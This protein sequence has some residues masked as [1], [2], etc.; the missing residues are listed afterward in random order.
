MNTRIQMRIIL[1]GSAVGIF[2]CSLVL[3]LSIHQD[4]EKNRI[5]SLENKLKVDAKALL[6][7]LYQ[8]GNSAWFK[9]TLQALVKDG[10]TCLEVMDQSRSNIWS[11]GKG[12]NKEVPVV[13]YI[14]QEILKIN[15]SLPE[16]SVLTSLTKGLHSTTALFLMLIT[17][18]GVSFY[19][20]SRIL[21]Q[22]EKMNSEAEKKDHILRLTRTLGHNLKSPLAALNSYYEMTSARLTKDEKYF[23]ISIQKNIR[24]LCERLIDQDNSSIP[25]SKVELSQLVKDAIDLKLVEIK[26]DSVNIEVNLPK[27]IHAEINENEF[28]VIISNLL[29]N[30][31]EAK[32]PGQGLTIKVELIE[33]NGNAYLSI[34][35][36]GIGVP[37][38]K[39]ANLFKYGSTTKK[40][41]KGCGLYHAKT[42]LESWAGKIEL[43]SEYLSY[44]SVRLQIPTLRQSTDTEIV[45]IDNEKLNIICWQAIA[46][47]RNISFK[48]FKH[49][50]E[51]YNE[52]NNIKQTTPIYIDYDLGCEFSGL[53][54]AQ[55]LRKLGFTN[56]T[57]ATGHEERI[58]T[59]FHQISK[60]FPRVIS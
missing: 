55:N 29:N 25:T 8:S 10:F 19:L 11:H 21:I 18:I 15:Y 16:I 30:S 56:L 52:M 38:S 13:N 26:D 39:I 53:Q 14:G 33:E 27:Q 58:S 44:T 2:L 34:T 9:D 12:C 1:I 4:Y 37:S 36:N 32:K 60:E 42:T 6:P 50:Q 41:G 17:L 5:L 45:L 49:P 23:F 54:V 31:L 35:D 20:F 28:S 48:G 51:F 24:S 46:K 7:H 40:N 59:E 57:L 3:T 43:N 47:K 22:N